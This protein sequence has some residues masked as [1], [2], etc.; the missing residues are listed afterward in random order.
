MSDKNEDEEI[1]ERLK[2]IRVPAKAYYLALADERTT[3]RLIAGRI[4]TG[5]GIAAIQTG[6][7]VWSYA[8]AGA[9]V[10]WVMVG[11]G[12]L[13]GLVVLQGA[14]LLW[15]RGKNLREAR[16]ARETLEGKQGWL[17]RHE[18]RVLAGIADNE[19][20]YV[21]ASALEVCRD[22]RDRVAVEDEGGLVE[23]WLWAAAVQ[24]HAL[25]SLGQAPIG[26]TA[27]GRL[28]EEYEK[29]QQKNAN[30]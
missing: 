9:A 29:L 23:Y 27:H 1:L 30:A 13:G 5:L 21:V 4:L 6:L 16:E 26:G 2:L 24:D 19:P 20:E 14:K 22:S 10:T 3:M 18:G 28:G 25:M 7:T 17:W 11:I 12:V 15:R 8:N